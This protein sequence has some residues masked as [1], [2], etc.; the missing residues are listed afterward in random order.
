MAH[1][2]SQMFII[3]LNQEIIFA[4][5][6]VPAYSVLLWQKTAVGVGCASIIIVGLS[7]ILYLGIFP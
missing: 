3:G 1:I 5:N 4:Q 7:L 6:V 2:H